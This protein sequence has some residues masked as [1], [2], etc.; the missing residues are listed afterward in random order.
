[1]LQILIDLVDDNVEECSVYREALPHEQNM[2][3]IILLVAIL[4]KNDKIIKYCIDHG[5]DNITEA[6][7]Y[8]ITYNFDID[9]DIPGNIN[10]DELS[11][12]AAK[13]DNVEL[14]KM[15]IS[16]G[17]DNLVECLETAVQHN[18]EQAITYLE[19]LL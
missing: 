4:Q 18:S 8:D 12:Q 11:M 14:I 13:L 15:C 7:A 10:I 5:A 1:M 6:F 3:N 9:Q 19:S 2:Y 16:G 17:S